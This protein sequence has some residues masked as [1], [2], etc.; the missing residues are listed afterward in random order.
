MSHFIDHEPSP[1]PNGSKPIWD[2]VIDD[3]RERDLVGRQ[4][5]GTPLQAH[6]GRRPLV[7]SYQECLD[8]VVGQS[9]GQIVLLSKGRDRIAHVHLCCLG[10][11]AALI[12]YAPCHQLI[13]SN[14]EAIDIGLWR[15][16][17][18]H[19]LLWAHVERATHYLALSC[20]SLPLVLGYAKIKDF[21]KIR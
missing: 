15:D 13:E 19:K 11:A 2:L 3:M 1:I 9:T 12:R 10:K 16:R 6:N 18:T 21:D 7:D 17:L 5:Y 8:L 4:R 20:Q 14:A